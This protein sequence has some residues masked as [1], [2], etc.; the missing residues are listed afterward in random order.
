MEQWMRCKISFFDEKKQFRHDVHKYTRKSELFMKLWIA[1]YIMS[2]ISF[3]EASFLPES[4]LRSV[5]PAY[6]PANMTE[7][8]FRAIISGIE[9]IYTPIVSVHGGKLSI[10][11]DWKSETP[12][13]GATQMF[14][15]WQVK[16]TGGLARRPELTQDGFALILCHELGHHLAGFSFAPVDNP[17]AGAWAANEGQSDYFA[18]HV[19]ARKIW[20]KEI[21]KNAGFRET[22]SPTI[23]RSCDAAWLDHEEQNLCYRTLSA[24]E[25][26][27]FTMAALMQKPM[28]AFDTPDPSQV[29]KTNHA[30]PAVQCRMDS[31]FQ[32]AIC[33]AGFNDRL[34]P[35]KKVREGKDSV[36]AE[37]EAARVSC[38]RY[39]N[40][41]AGLR[42]ACWFKSRL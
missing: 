30:H 26:V 41:E 37:R 3:A 19:C 27:A 28:P 1:L 36:E 20:E 9:K 16:I 31:S 40:Y 13:A 8:E 11:G 5:V 35:G 18:T 17:F 23:R 14:G 38:T 39:S 33:Q 24:A 12:N 2:F 29:E 42:P 10:S 32:G 7:P 34:I 6:G 25:S 4:D 22:A 21:E 15:N